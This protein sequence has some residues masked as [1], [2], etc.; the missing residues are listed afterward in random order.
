MQPKTVM[1]PA[2]ARLLNRARDILAL[3]QG[4]LADA[5]SG[6]QSAV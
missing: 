4:K 5:R 6:A 3:D 1:F 2:D